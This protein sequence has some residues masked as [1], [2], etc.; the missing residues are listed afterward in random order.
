MCDGFRLYRDDQ[1]LVRLAERIAVPPPQ[2]TTLF[3]EDD[4]VLLFA[5]TPAA[6]HGDEE[7]LR[8]VLSGLT[9]VYLR[10]GWDLP[11]T[12]FALA[13][14][15]NLSAR[16]RKLL[17]A[18]FTQ[19]RLSGRFEDSY[20]LFEAPIPG[21]GD[22]FDLL[23]GRRL[24][25]WV[26]GAVLVN[27]GWRTPADEGP[28]LGLVAPSEHPR[29]VEVRQ[30]T[31]IMRDS[32]YRTARTD[33][34]GEPQFFGGDTRVESYGRIGD[35]LCRL[36]GEPTAPT[37]YRRGH[38]FAAC[39]L[40]GLIDWAAA[41]GHEPGT[42]AVRALALGIAEDDGLFGDDR[43][44]IDDNGALALT[45]EL[46]DRYRALTEPG[47]PNVLAWAV[48]EADTNNPR[49]SQDTPLGQTAGWEELRRADPDAW[50][51]DA[52][53]YARVVCHERFGGTTF[54]GLLTQLATAFG[55]DDAALLQRAFAQLGFQDWP[56]WDISAPSPQTADAAATPEEQPG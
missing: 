26:S 6:D 56:Q 12:I 24:P 3:P 29:R 40:S 23:A 16:T 55:D 46:V 28:L 18:R 41:T 38:L 49:S 11:A 13:R 34:G 20:A 8:A 42:P 17:R 32:R 43:P 48:E 39:A 54:D 9:R 31:L 1:D 7:L 10:A 50:W 37:R 47:I 27:E 21:E 14:S 44:H 25:S 33:R 36:L 45:P 22:V 15:T 52:G 2:P 19:Q 5:P 51:M 35:A 53:M 4:K 30:V